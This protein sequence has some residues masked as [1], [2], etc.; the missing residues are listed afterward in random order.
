MRDLVDHPLIE[1]L[2]MDVCDQTSII[3]A[4]DNLAE[5]TDRR[6]DILFNSAG[7]N[8]YVTTIL[9]ASID[10]AKTVFET[11]FFSVIRVT[12]AF[13]PLLRRSGDARVINVGSVASEVPLPTMS[14]YGCSKAALALLGDTL[15][16]ELAPFGIQVMTVMA[17][18]VK[19]SRDPS[20]VSVNVPPGSLYVPAK[21]RFAFIIAR[22]EEGRMST[23]AFA[24]TVVTEVLRTRM[25]ARV[26]A[27]SN[28]WVVWLVR[29]IVP[30]W[31]L[32]FV[33]LRTYG[34]DG[35]SAS[36]RRS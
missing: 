28:S 18:T 21:N 22:V 5:M 15:R 27:G 34:L 1:T 6:L 17:G 12:Q 26:W 9:D 25:K 8:D 20:R 32:E 7:G 35:L 23:E 24:E 36:R 14:M 29:L 3:R 31:F 19:N 10:D 4:R 30:T 33:L 16:V 13:T 2:Q 11:N